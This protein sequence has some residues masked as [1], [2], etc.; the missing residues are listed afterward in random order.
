MAKKRDS[1][2]IADNRRARHDYSFDETIECGIELK[3]TEVKSMKTNRFS[4]SDAYA[5]IRDNELWLIGLHVTPYPFGNI[6]NHDPDRDRKLLAHRQEIKRLKRKVD[7]K[8]YTLIPINFHLKD[9]KV[10]VQV[11]LGKG[12]RAY[13]KREDIKRRDQKR[14]AEREIR[15]RLK[16]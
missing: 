8:G 2:I 11:G 13:D 14:E 15:K 9:G 5:R 6:Y 16:Y 4:F 7:E 3:G 1:S 10:K 12:K